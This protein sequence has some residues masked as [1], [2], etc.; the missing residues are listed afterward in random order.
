MSRKLSAVLAVVVCTWTGLQGKPLPDKVSKP[1]PIKPFE[2]AELGK[3]VFHLSFPG[4]AMASIKVRSTEESDVDLFIQ[5]MDGTEVASDTDES[6]NCQVTFMP[7]KG[8]LYRVS[9]VNLGPGGNRCTLTHNGMVENPDF[10][11]IVQT[12]PIKI[13]EDEKHTFNLKVKEGKLTAVW[14]F[15][16]SATD[17][18][19][20]VFEA[21]GKEI[22]KDEHVSRDAFVSFTPKAS[23]TYR[24]EVRNLG[25]GENMV[26]VKHSAGAP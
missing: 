24:I 13:D 19:I 4:D 2:I 21:D 11:K 17:V 20:F 6:K 7:Q 26:T 8:K 3:K 9:V 16:E 10:G 22:A 1:Q 25:Q 5:E 18:D 23:G 14:A 12:K 15:G